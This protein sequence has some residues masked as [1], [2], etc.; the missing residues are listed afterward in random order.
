MRPRG[1]A[2]PEEPGEG[3]WRPG[4]VAWGAVAVAVL[5]LAVGVGYVVGTRPDR[6]SAVD[7]GFLQDMIDHHGQAIVMGKTLQ[8]AGGSP[9][10]G[11]FADEIV[12]TARGTG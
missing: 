3:S 6:P 11:S 1:E 2:A 7:V 9:E 4:P 8:T 10:V 12:A 5:L